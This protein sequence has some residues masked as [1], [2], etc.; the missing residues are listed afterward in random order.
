ME[1]K[2]QDVR[3]KSNHINHYI[4]SEFKHPIKREILKRQEQLYA[5]YK[6]WKK[7]YHANINQKEARMTC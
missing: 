3:L 5:A 7:V 6:G 2:E 4:K 1:N